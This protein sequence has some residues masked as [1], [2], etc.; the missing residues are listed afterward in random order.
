M[1]STMSAEMGRRLV[2]VTD[3]TRI[4]DHD[5]S[6]PDYAACRDL[7]TGHP[8]ACPAGVNPSSVATPRWVE[9]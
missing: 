1:F 6:A 8:R 7:G 4:E 3:G 2:G 5:P 9:G